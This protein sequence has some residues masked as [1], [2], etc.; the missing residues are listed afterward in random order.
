MKYF[1]I[2]ELCRSGKAVQLGIDNTPTKEVTDSLSVLVEKVLDP[3]REMLGKPV[4]VNSG[5]RCP[6][7]NRILNGSPVSQHMKG[8]AADITTGSREGNKQLYEIIRNNLEY[9]QLINEYDYSWIHVSFR[10]S[11]NRKQQLKIG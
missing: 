4:T 1:T 2:D 3:A 9:D 8:E 11:G 6:E 5:Y 10:K 7:L